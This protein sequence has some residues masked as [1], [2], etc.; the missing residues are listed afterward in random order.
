VTLLERLH[1]S[2][3]FDRIIVVGHSLGTV[4]AY[5]AISIAWSRIDKADWAAAHS[6]AA[7]AK[8]LVKVETAAVDLVAASKRVTRATG[9]ARRA[10]HEAAAVARDAYRTAQADYFAHVQ[11][12][13]TKVGKGPNAEPSRPLWLVSDFVTTAAPLSKADVLLARNGKQLEERKA[14]REYPTCPPWLEAE[15]KAQP[16]TR[17]SYE[18]GGVFLPHHAAPFGP[19]RWTN[20]YFGTFAAILGDFIAGPVAPRFGPGVLD[21][22]LPSGLSIRH[23]DYWRKPSAEPA[24]KPRIRA[25]RRAVNLLDRTD[26][27]NWGAQRLEPEVDG[28]KLL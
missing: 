4:V 23:L 8:A 27:R 20:V 18:L 9:Q 28:M 26:E 10:A 25:L 6:H 11:T 7:A 3:E 2:D 24:T 22:R 14:Y 16:P 12:M 17:F 5:D 13:R 15:T 19:T 21:V 1:A